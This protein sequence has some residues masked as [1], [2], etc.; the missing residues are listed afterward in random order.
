MNLLTD[1][2]CPPKAPKSFTRSE[3]IRSIY[4]RFQRNREDEEGPRLRRLAQA[5]SL[6]IA[7][8]DEIAGALEHGILRQN[9][10]K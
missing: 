8:S 3:L 9:L 10:A 6:V 5:E 7:V 4:E 2:P 1:F